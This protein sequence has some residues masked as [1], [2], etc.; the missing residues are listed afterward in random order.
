MSGR[1]QGTPATFNNE[2][3]HASRT[4]GSDKVDGGQEGIEEH[5]K[6]Q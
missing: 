3:S 4:S 2:E 6:W 5:G 1:A